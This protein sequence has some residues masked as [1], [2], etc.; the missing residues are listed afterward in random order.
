MLSCF[1]SLVFRTIPRPFDA[2]KTR[3]GLN[4]IKTLNRM[5]EM[6]FNRWSVP[7]VNRVNKIG[8]SKTQVTF[9]RSLVAGH[10]FTFWK[11]TLTL[12]LANPIGLIRVFRP[13]V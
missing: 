4:V 8:G 2:T 6:C 5:K 13:S 11:V 1:V 9:H 10:C 12:N 3:G 7:D